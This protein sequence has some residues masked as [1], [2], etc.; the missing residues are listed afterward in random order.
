MRLGD[1]VKNVSGVSLTQQRQGVAETFSAR[2]YS[3]GIGAAQAAF[4]K[5]DC[6][7]YRWLS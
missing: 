5:R 7:Q 4:L 1:V 6:Q 2:G 3:I